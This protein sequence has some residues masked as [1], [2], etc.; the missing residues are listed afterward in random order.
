MKKIAH[1]KYLF[2]LSAIFIAW[3]ILLS[4]N[5][6]DRADWALENVLVL[7]FAVLIAG[8]NISL[9]RDFA[10]EWNHSQSVKGKHPL[11][12]DAIKKMLD[13]RDNQE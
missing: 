7:A 13:S 1:T 12:E 11:G 4:I 5:P 3:F 10:K 2:I 8:I 9:Q 6:Y